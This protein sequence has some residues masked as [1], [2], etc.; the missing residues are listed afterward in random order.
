MEGDKGKPDLILKDFTMPVRL[1]ASFL[2]EVNIIMEDQRTVV[3]VCYTTFHVKCAWKMA[4][5]RK[6]GGQHKALRTTGGG[7]EGGGEGRGSLLRTT[8]SQDKR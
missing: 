1:P 5:D 3:Q 4:P 8:P 2:E 6:K 7:D